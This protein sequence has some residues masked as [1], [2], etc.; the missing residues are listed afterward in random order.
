MT[1]ESNTSRMS[2]A[3]HPGG[4]RVAL[5][6]GVGNF[7]EWF[8]FA[9][10][11]FMAVTLAKLFFPSGNETASLLAT[12]AV[13]GVAFLFRPLGGIVLGG[14][15]DRAGRRASLSL[16][17]LLMGLFTTLIGFLPTHAQ[18]GLWAPVL[19]VLLRS[20]Q[21]FSAGGEYA[22]AAAFLIEY[23]PSGRR[24]LYSSVVSATAALGVVG[25]G[26]IA[27]LL[28]SVLSADQMSA[29][30]WRV[31]FLLAG[32]LAIVGLYVRLK[33][34]DTP[35]FRDLERQHK[36]TESPLL[37]AGKRSASSIGLVF[38]C[39]AVAGLGFYY[40]ATYVVTYLTVTVDMD[41]TSALFVAITSLCVYAAMC[42]VAG[43][44]GDSIGRRPTMLIGT[45]GLAVLGIPCFMLMG[46]GELPLVLLGLWVFAA[47]EALA[48]VTLG[49]LLVELFP[50]QVRV[51][52]SAIGFNVAQ[53]LIGGQGPLVAAFLAA[54]LPFVFAPALYVVGVAAVMFFVLLKFL[55]ETRG[56]ALTAETAPRAGAPAWVSMTS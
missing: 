41:A 18:I 49:V 52:G 20:G 26:L 40:L 38:A 5:A 33:M 24:G 16:C 23:A 17:I 37:G 54:S 7:L 8:D 51:S 25:G 15:G 22:G 53:A 14:F 44:I 2:E 46:T 43:R 32:P 6:A 27:L 56:T 11:G 9:L 19:L 34:E 30:G 39:T 35:V 28:T 1:S 50:A 4:R 21:G 10:Y 36:V 42:P 45:A 48:N 47:C 55:P 31:P 12:M 13:F 3:P 29:W